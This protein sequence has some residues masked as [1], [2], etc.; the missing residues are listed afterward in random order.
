MNIFK[1]L[2]VG[3]KILAGNFIALA[4]MVLVGGV[5][6]VRLN[7]IENTV[8]DLADNLAVDQHLA[9][10]IESKILLVRF[11]ANKY[12]RDQKPKD[13]TQYQEALT[14]FETLLTEA[15]TKI[16]KPER[17]E[18]LRQIETGAQIYKTT[19]AE[20]MQ[21]ITDRDQTVSTIL[22]V[23]GPL[24]QKKLDQLAQAAFDKNDFAVVYHTLK[25]SEALQLMRFSAFRYLEHGNEIWF[26]TFEEHYGEAKAAIDSLEV[27][28]QD[29]DWLELMNESVAGIDRYAEGFATLHNDYSRQN[30][31]IETQMNVV[32]PQIRQTASDISAS[33]QADFQAQNMATT[34]LVVQSRIILSIIMGV[35]VVLVTVIALFLVRTIARTVNIVTSAAVGIAEGDLEQWVEVDSHDELGRM[36]AAFQQM[37]AHLKYMASATDRLAQGDLTADIEPKSERDV[38]GNALARM[39]THLRQLVGQMTENATN[40]ARSSTQLT[41]TAEQTGQ[42]TSQIRVTMHQLA[43][44]AQQ[45][46]ASALQTKAS[47]DQIA[48]AIDGVAHG[49]QEQAAAVAE[50]ASIT[51]QISLGIQQIAANAQAGANGASNAAET[52]RRGASIVDDTIQ[53]METIKTKVGLSAQRVQEMGQRSQQIGAIVATIEE[54]SAQTNLLALNAAIEAARAGEH[55]KGFAVVADEVRKLAEKST[56]ATGEIA[57]IIQTIQLAVTEAVTAMEDGA[58]EVESGVGR[59]NEAGQALAG[60]LKAVEAVDD[61][62]KEISLAAQHMS[63]SSKVL[64]QTMERVSAVVEQNSA[65]TEEMAAS[66]N[67]VSQTVDNIARVSQENSVAVEEVSF[68]VEKMGSQVQ[69]VSISAQTL[70]EMAQSL[71][72][73]IAQFK[74]KKV[75]VSTGVLPRSDTF[76]PKE[77]ERKP[78][79]VNGNG[80]HHT[81]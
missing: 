56:T 71:K 68:S 18:M 17:V 67:D 2:P 28:I 42:A 62:V 3:T 21:L 12:I 29:A 35:A 59:A 78:I 31:L 39:I 20:V 4:L 13:T 41:A 24:A 69:E 22:D 50:S 74:L 60:I 15:D 77:V 72:E 46:S 75:D 53:G 52:A 23:E 16:T 26:G 79:L 36:A 37:I 51:N 25:A 58:A 49:A 34:G 45:Q 8:S 33:V 6:I 9:D 65:A 66:S 27:N 43:S 76:Q 47:I 5:A 57:D 38:L 19:F 63:T 80:Y 40:V 81:H 64:V 14:G 7:T 44:A 48:R 54:I 10:Q 55:G 11:Y 1:N 32:G 73:A 70:N 61:Q 30:E